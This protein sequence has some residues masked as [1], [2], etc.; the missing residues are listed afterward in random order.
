MSSRR[1][2]WTCICITRL[3]KEIK[4][5]WVIR[6]STNQ[7]FQFVFA[8]EQDKKLHIFFRGPFSH[9]IWHEWD[10]SYIIN[11]IRRHCRFDEESTHTHQ[12]NPYSFTNGSIRW[13]FEDNFSPVI[14]K[15]LNSCRRFNFFNPP[16][17]VLKP[18]VVWYILES[19]WL[20]FGRKI[21]ADI[22]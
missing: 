5:A 9:Y 15:N 4:H 1:Y 7:R 12:R 6:F 2:N 19:K 17:P 22:A 14:F 11:R 13:G 10:A 3:L 16:S 8:F 21:S 18:R 20:A